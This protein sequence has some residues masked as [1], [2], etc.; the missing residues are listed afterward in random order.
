MAEG[1]V[2]GLIADVTEKVRRAIMLAYA[3]GRAD[4]LA[5]ANQLPVMRFSG[6]VREYADDYPVLDFDGDGGKAYRAAAKVRRKPP[7]KHEKLHSPDDFWFNL[8]AEFSA[9]KIENPSLTQADF[10]RMKA[11][12]RIKQKTFNA[13]MLQLRRNGRFTHRPRMRRN[14]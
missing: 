14:K 7:E 2:E 13:K 9:M 5:G 3:Q 6:A 8:C 4:A 1:F 12:P 11:S 10:V